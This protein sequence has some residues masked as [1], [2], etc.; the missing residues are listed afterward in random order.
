MTPDNGPHARTLTDLAFHILIAL[1]EGPGHAGAAMEE[2]FARRLND[3]RASGLLT[4]V[5]VC[6][7]EFA[8][9]IGLL[10]S[11]RWGAAQLRRQRQ[12]TQSRWKA[13]GLNSM[14]GDTRTARAD[15]MLVDGFR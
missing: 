3:A 15:L 7:R 11:E 14:P 2:T 8:G 6:G 10:L 1:G 9:L 4:C 12:R 13:G 5:R